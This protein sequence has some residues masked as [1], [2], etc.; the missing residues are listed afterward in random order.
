MEIGLIALGLVLGGAVL[1]FLLR[2]DFET[3][4]RI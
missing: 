1:Y 2:P 4:G 3:L